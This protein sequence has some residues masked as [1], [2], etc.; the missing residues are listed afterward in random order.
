MWN[1]LF[2]NTNPQR[3]RRAVAFTGLSK[4]SRA[5]SGG[6][7]RLQGVTGALQGYQRR[8]KGFQVIS[9]MFKGASLDR[10]E[11]PSGFR[12]IPRVLGGFRGYHEI[13]GSFQGGHKILKREPGGLGVFRG[14]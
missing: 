5:V 4:L 11:K 2:S 6:S 13:S 7:R 1:V 12:G 9:G 8:S 3:Q 10:R 14:L